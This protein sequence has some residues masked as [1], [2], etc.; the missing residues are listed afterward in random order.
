M[1]NAIAAWLVAFM[2]AGVF[3]LLTNAKPFASAQPA[4]TYY[5]APA[6]TATVVPL[7]IPVS[8]AT[9]TSPI[10]DSASSNEGKLF[11]QTKP[12]ITVD[13]IRRVLK[14]KKSPAI[15]EAQFIYDM[16]VQYGVNPAVC[17]AFFIVESQAGTL[18]V[19]RF[20]RGVGNIRALKGEDH[21]QG[22]RRYDTWREGI[23]HLY[24]LIS[25][26]HYMGEGRLT[27]DRI[28]VKYAPPSENDT[29]E[30]IKSVKSY[31]A[32]WK[33]ESGL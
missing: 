26:P 13:V 2:I 18:G 15:A 31:V 16:G 21:Y 9:V 20:T 4:T 3:S 33:S 11:L 29:D 23:K 5:F 1:R 28:L 6:S 10:T 30:Y 27:V 12:T 22:Y 8:T 24:D 17:L 14:E 32:K 7:A 19:A 25:G